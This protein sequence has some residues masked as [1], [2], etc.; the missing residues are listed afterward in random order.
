MRKIFFKCNAENGINCTKGI[1]VFSSTHIDADIH[2]ELK[3]ALDRCVL[4]FITHTKKNVNNQ[5]ARLRNLIF[6]VNF[7]I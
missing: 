4:I 2:A 5:P 7:L 3:T 1:F 6:Y